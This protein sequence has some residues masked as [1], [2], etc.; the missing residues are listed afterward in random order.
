MPDNRRSELLQ[1][2][3]AMK[4]SNKDVDRISLTPA[5]PHTGPTDFGTALAIALILLLPLVSGIFGHDPWTPDEPRVAATSKEMMLSGDW[6][7]PTLGG[8]PFVEQPPLFYL[9]AGLAW[10]FL[11]PV[12]GE[13]GSVRFV[14][15]LCGLGTLLLMARIAFLLAGARVAVIAAVMLVTS[16]AFIIASH[17]IRVDAALLL[18]VVAAIAATVEAYHRDRPWFLPIAGLCTAAA[19]LSKGPVAL[20]FIVPAVAPFTWKWLRRGREAM[21]AS[22]WSSHAIAL[23]LALAVAGAWM[24]A[25]KLHNESAWKA[26]FWDNQF[27]RFTGSAEALGHHHGGKPTYYIETLLI[28]MAPWSFALILWVRDL[29]RNRRSK[30][31]FDTATLSLAAWGFGALLLLTLSVTKRDIYLAP[32]LPAFCIMAAMALE[33]TPPAWFRWWLAAWSGI[34]LVAAIVAA[35]SPLLLSMPSLRAMPIPP[36]TTSW[37]ATWHAEHFSAMALAAIAIALVICRK[38]MAFHPALVPAGVLA[39]SLSALLTLCSVAV[40]QSKNLREPAE[41]FAGA[42]PRHMQARACAFLLTETDRGALSFHTD[43]RIRSI[44]TRDELLAVLNGRHPRFDT[45]VSSLPPERIPELQ[46]YRCRVRASGDLGDTRHPRPLYW[47][48]RDGK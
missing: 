32:A 16:P 18:F 21:T 12:L 31:W 47:I 36:A 38:R 41:M 19:L 10:Q 48:A 7:V 28:A 39:L 33:S 43:W 13:T 15:L 24:A 2:L 25:L 6:V 17:T 40:N 3:R 45:V 14:P 8:D 26:W 46:G 35:F 30:T 23:V 9:M 20:V 1:S 11:A 5:G 22:W 4:A 27:G 44:H 34:F 42:V 37:L 29:W